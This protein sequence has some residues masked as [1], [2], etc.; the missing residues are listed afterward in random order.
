MPT[1]EKTTIT[2]A[3]TVNAPVEKVWQFWTTPQHIT[4]WNNASEDWHTPKAA[5]DL[6]PGGTFNYRMEAKDNSFGFD[7]EG[8]YTEV[9]TNELIEYVIADGRKVQILF[10]ALDD[11]THITETFEAEEVHP[12]ELQQD[13]WQ[14]ILN[15]FKRYTETH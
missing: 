1:T 10:E 5:N 4:Q 6:R 13:G 11:E 8:R 9:K 2:V 3:A 15:N 12:V 14:A 7:F